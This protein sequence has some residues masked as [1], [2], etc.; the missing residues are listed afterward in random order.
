KARPKTVL[1]GSR[2]SGRV[3]ADTDLN[4]ETHYFICQ[5]FLLQRSNSENTVKPIIYDRFSGEIRRVLAPA[6]GNPVPG[7]LF[8]DCRSSPCSR[9]VRLCA[10]C[11]ITS[12]A[13]LFVAAIL[14]RQE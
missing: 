6:A 11:S 14:M 4:H 13:P 1:T 10:R 8:K 3:F 12:S 9:C 5:P 7:C 2:S